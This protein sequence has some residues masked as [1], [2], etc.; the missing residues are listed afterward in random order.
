M[1]SAGLHEGIPLQHP[2]PHR[3]TIS[4]IYDACTSRLRSVPGRCGVHPRISHAH[5]GRSCGP[6]TR[7]PESVETRSHPARKS[8]EGRLS[9]SPTPMSPSSDSK[10]RASGYCAARCSPASVLAS[11][12]PASGS[13]ESTPTWQYTYRGTDG[14]SG[15]QW[16]HDQGKGP[17]PITCLVVRGSTNTLTPPPPP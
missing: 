17:R 16:L 8:R 14:R 13:Q 1:G 12:E 4:E 7:L 2:P 3:P 9:L 11:G 6:E 5:G 10:E 15:G